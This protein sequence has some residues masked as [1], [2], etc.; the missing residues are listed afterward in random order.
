MKLNH[1]DRAVKPAGEE[2][3]AAR[4]GSPCKT[5]DGVRRASLRNPG[6]AGRFWPIAALLVG[7]DDPHRTS[8]RALHWAKIGSVKVV[9]FHVIRL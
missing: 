8:P 5:R 3:G 1:L 2:R 7:H 6:G 4:A 9:Q